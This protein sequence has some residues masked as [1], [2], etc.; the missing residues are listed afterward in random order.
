[1][2]M[3]I[4]L[5]G[6]NTEGVSPGDE[7]VESPHEEAKDFLRRHPT[8]KIVVAIDTHCLENGAF[9]YTGNS[10]PTYEACFLPEVRLL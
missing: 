8:A 6:E 1:M 5:G 10:P 2:W 3:N 4:A 7:E 9:V